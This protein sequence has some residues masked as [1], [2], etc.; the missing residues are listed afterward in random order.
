MGRYRAPVNDAPAPKL[1]CYPVGV[2]GFEPGT[3]C[4]PDKRANQAAPH[5]VSTSTLSPP[6]FSGRPSE[7]GGLLGGIASDAAA[8]C[9]TP[10]RAW[11]RDRGLAAAR[12]ESGGLLGG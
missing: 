2:P 6:G 8:G 10:R 3:S 5:P 7:S 12:S 4:P 11:Y 1:A 9:A